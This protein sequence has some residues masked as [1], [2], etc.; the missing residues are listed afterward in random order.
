MKNRTVLVTG[1][2]GEIG[3]SIAE[4]FAKIGCNVVIHTFSKPEFADKLCETL[5]SK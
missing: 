2:T 1:A 5:E 3:A 4:N